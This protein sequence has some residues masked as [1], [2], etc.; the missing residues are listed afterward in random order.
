MSPFIHIADVPEKEIVKG[1][2]GRMIHADGVTVAH[3]RVEAGSVLPQHHHI[4]EQVTNILSG[5]FEM[6]IGG[7][8]QVCQ[9]GDVVVIP[10]NVPHSA[11]AISDCTILDV[12]CPVRE[13]YR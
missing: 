5:A 11:V 8:T 9:A 4:H 2:H 12:F 7:V 13:D 10:S 3:F 6:T 1:Y